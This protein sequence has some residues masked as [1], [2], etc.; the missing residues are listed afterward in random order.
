MG[1]LKMI[2]CDFYSKGLVLCEGYSIH[3]KT[4]FWLNSERE[5]SYFHI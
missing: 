3:S 4:N 2:G 5:Q 1:F